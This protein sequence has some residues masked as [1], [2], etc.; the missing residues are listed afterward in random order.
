MDSAVCLWSNPLG[1]IF[2]QTNL[3]IVFV[4]LKDDCSTCNRKVKVIDINILR[5]FLMFLSLLQQNKR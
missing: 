3:R 1:I 5:T 2:I 4:I